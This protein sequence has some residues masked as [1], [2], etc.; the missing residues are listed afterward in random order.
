VFSEQSQ[1]GSGIYRRRRI[2]EEGRHRLKHSKV[3]Q[4]TA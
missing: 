4:V 2:D 1:Q 3:P